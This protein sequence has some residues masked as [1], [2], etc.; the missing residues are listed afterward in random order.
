MSDA[1][2][3]YTL[4]FIGVICIITGV[5]FSLYTKKEIPAKIIGTIGLLTTLFT[6]MYFRILK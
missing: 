2:L 3:S 6:L 1:E 5:Y 4:L